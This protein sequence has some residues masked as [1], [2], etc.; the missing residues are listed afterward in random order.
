M[1]YTDHVSPA[2]VDLLLGETTGPS[3]SIHLP[4]SL[5]TQDTDKDRIVLKNL[6]SEAFDQL[7]A[8]GL[9]RPDAEAVLLPVDAVLEDDGFWPYLSD[10]LAI[11][12]SPDVHTL[13]RLPVRFEPEVRVGDRFHLRPLIPLL[14][15]GGVFFVIA[16]SEQRVRLFEGTRQHLKPVEVPGLPTDMTG[17]LA[18]LGREPGRQPH[19]RWQGDEGQK[20]LYRMFFEQID[21][22]LRPEYRQHGDPLVFAGVEYL[23][24]IFRDA[25]CYRKLLDTF[26]SGNVDRMAVDD[27]HARAWPLV[28]PVF[29]APRQA[30]IASY[31]ALQGTGRTSADLATILGAA[32]DG[33]VQTLFVQESAT[34]FGTFDEARRDLEV[35]ETAG[36]QDLDL[37]AR[38]ARWAYGTGATIFAGESPEIPEAAPLAAV[39]RYA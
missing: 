32:H 5:V 4:T 31:R 38:A 17:A 27:L 24:P 2:D 15:E 10:G 20:L 39:F 30:A 26:V 19:R 1:P 11:Y 23:F 9:R 35:H 14:S 16:V 12:C 13:H 28:E 34:V 21:R 33:R 6:R 25:I 8:R 7:V 36:P 3:V 29:A 22:A 37:I 18:R